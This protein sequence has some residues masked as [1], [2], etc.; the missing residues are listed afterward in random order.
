MADPFIHADKQLD[1]GCI[2]S[3]AGNMQILVSGNVT[4]TFYG[5]MQSAGLIG[6]GGQS[7]STGKLVLRF[8]KIGEKLKMP[9]MYYLRAA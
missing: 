3:S 6:I 1:R 7:G 4:A 8:N 2:L 9:N 5:Q